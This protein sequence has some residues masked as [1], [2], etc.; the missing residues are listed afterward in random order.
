MLRMDPVR[1]SPSA[2]SDFKRHVEGKR[3]KKD[4]D[5]NRI[6]HKD[7]SALLYSIQEKM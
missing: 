7:T 3:K 6:L 4:Q 1:S 2:F 5:K